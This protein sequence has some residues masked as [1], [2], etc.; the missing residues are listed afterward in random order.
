V[1]YHDRNAGRIA[2]NGGPSAGMAGAKQALFRTRI[3][4]HDSV[5]RQRHGA[6]SQQEDQQE[7]AQSL[8]ELK[9]LLQMRRLSPLAGDPAPIQAAFE[10]AS[11]YRNGVRNW[12]G[13]NFHSF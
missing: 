5:R 8:H 6:E 9:I 10:P 13:S 12:V 1:A 11:C 4:V 7:V 3:C 2:H